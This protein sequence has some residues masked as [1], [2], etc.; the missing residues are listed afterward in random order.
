MRFLQGG[1]GRNTGAD[2]LNPPGYFIAFLVRFFLTE[3]IGV[4]LMD[5][6][7]KRE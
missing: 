4:S 2:R 5:K 7:N 1:G 3:E 6:D